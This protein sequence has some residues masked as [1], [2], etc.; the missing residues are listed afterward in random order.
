LV[1]LLAHRFRA[2]GSGRSRQRARAVNLLVRMTQQLRDVSQSLRVLEVEG[3]AATRDRPKFTLPTEDAWVRPRRNGLHGLAGRRLVQL[4]NGITE[5]LRYRT[6]QRSR[7][8]EIEN[9]SVALQRDK[10]SA[11][12]YC[13][14][15]AS[16]FEGHHPIVAAMEN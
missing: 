14:E 16:R 10:T 3:F 6:S 5:E 4:L 8:A 15:F 7:V 13:S 12:N 2:F 11:R 9:V 1:D